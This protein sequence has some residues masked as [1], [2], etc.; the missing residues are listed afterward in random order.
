MHTVKRLR[1]ILNPPAA[2]ETGSVLAVSADGLTVATAQGVKNFAKLPGD[3]TGYR[4]GDQCGCLAGQLLA[5]GG[6]QLII[7]WFDYLAAISRS[8]HLGIQI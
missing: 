1:Q 4:P 6:R 3:V 7:M 8:S 5:V 2:P